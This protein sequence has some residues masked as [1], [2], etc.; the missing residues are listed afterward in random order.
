MRI[1]GMDFDSQNNLW[2][3][4]SQVEDNLHVLKTDGTWKSFTLPEV[5]IKYCTGQVL[6]DSYDNIWVVIPRNDTY[7]LYVMSNDG[8]QKLHLNVRSFFTNG[9]EDQIT[10]MN[11][12]YCLAEDNE[13][14]N[15]VGTSNG[16]C[17]YEVLQWFLQ[18]LIQILTMAISQR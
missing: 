6:V 1:G 2:V 9:Q 14:Q 8:S 5:S 18:I 11:D 15:W 17:V 3:S 16:V 10:I 7:G 4:N 13:G 12:V